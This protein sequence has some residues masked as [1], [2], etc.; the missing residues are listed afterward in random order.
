MRRLVT[1]DLPALHRWLPHTCEM[2]DK[3]ITK[4]PYW[5][6]P[7]TGHRARGHYYHEDCDPSDSRAKPT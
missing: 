7:K 2:C 1:K 6:V 3:P 4:P 5:A